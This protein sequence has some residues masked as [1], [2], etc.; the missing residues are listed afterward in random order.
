[1]L[2]VEPAAPVPAAEPAAVA[3]APPAPLPPVAAFIISASEL[4]AAASA[5]LPT[6]I[7][8]SCSRAS[9]LESRFNFSICS[10]SDGGCGGFLRMFLAGLLEAGRSFAITGAGRHS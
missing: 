2:G 6:A 10:G 1:M 5:L 9:R 3:G 8:L 4:L 7:A